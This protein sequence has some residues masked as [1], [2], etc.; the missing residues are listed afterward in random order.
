MADR[1]N[2]P[3]DASR[4][5]H[6][7]SQPQRSSVMFVGQRSLATQRRGRY[8]AGSAAHPARMAPD[9]AAALIEDYTRPGDLVLDP[10]AGTG[11]SLVEAVHAG[12]NAVGIDIEPGWIAVARANLDLARRPGASGHG[13]VIRGDAPRLPGGLPI[14]RR[15]RVALIL[16]SP[17]TGVTMRIGTPGRS[18][19]GLVRGMTAVLAGCV[20]AR[21]RWGDRG[22][23]ATVA[24]CRSSG[25]RVR[26]R[27]Q[28]GRHRRS[29]ARRPSRRHWRCRS[30]RTGRRAPCMLWTGC[31]VVHECDT[32]AGQRPSPRRRRRVHSDE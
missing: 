7:A 15:G 19:L 4:S 20:A 6:E 17:P 2:T 23:G 8:V 10:L 32:S 16:T 12:R 1:R 13:R 18:R 28:G 3:T 27:R 9:L 31:G 26:H 24:T 21:G 14:E 11:T 25:R 29:D 5:T 30:R 22:G